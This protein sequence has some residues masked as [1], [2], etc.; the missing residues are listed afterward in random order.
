MADRTDNRRTDTRD[1]V[2]AVALDLF[3]HQ[4]YQVTSLREIAE[5]LGVT[6][7]AVYFHFRTKQEILTALLHGYAGD[8]SALAADAEAGQP[9]TRD[10]RAELLRRYAVLQEQ[11]G[12]GF[13][14][15]LRQNYAEIRDLPIGA[16]VQDGTASLVRA[17]AP[18]GAGPEDRLRVRVALTTF[19]IAAS[20]AATEDDPATTEA[21]IALA[22]DILH[23]GD[24]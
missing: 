7:A 20:T 13:V 18:A 24:H 4:G 9:L 22:L 14:L 23:G 3:A 21:T 15:L 11:W 8:V 17:L 6:K 2:L 19:Q 1:R 5:R 16:A 12:S 10:G